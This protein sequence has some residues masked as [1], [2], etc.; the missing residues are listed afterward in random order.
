MKRKVIKQG[1]GTL[2]ITLPIEWTREM[3]LKGDEEI[4][5]TVSDNRLLVE[6]EHG[7]KEKI[8]SLDID[9]LERLSFAKFIIAC[10]E[11]GYDTIDVVFSKPHINSWSHGK[12]N[13]S[14]VINF[15]VSRLV[16][17]EVLSQT[18]NSIKIGN[19]SEKHL[20]FENILSR[21]FFLIEEYLSHLIEGLETNN[22]NDMKEGEK[23]HDNITKLVALASRI[24]HESDSFSRSESMNLFTILNILDKIT[25]FIRYAYKNTLKFNDKVS[26]NT[27]SLARKAYQFLETYRSFYNKFD[28]RLVNDLDDLR[29]EVKKSFL[30]CIKQCPKEAGINSNLDALVECLNGAVKLRISLELEKSH[31]K[32]GFPY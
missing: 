4:E 24:L 17:F 7:K 19:I 28:Y 29:G 26:K 21:I 1:N 5:V 18:K 30:E 8:I 11:Q 10:Y 23:R 16:G 9:H 22:Y 31:N 3:G 27:I 32:K 20:K 2:T 13:V 12:E 6:S 15:F 25:D 14:D